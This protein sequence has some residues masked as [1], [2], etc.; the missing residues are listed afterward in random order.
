MGFDP[1]REEANGMVRS[2][3]LGT[4]AMV[5]IVVGFTVGDARGWRSG[6][7]WSVV[8]YTVLLV[9]VI[10]L[11]RLQRHRK[12]SVNRAHWPLGCGGTRP[13]R[14]VVDRSMRPGPETSNEAR[15]L[16]PRACRIDL[17]ETETG[18]ASLP[19]LQARAGNGWTTAALAQPR[20]RA[21]HLRV[22]GRSYLSRWSLAGPTLDRAVP[23]LGFLFLLSI[24]ATLLDLLRRR[25]D[26][27]DR[28]QT[29]CSLRMVRGTCPGLTSR[30]RSGA[31][32]I[33]RSEI[34]FQRMIGGVRFLPG[35]RVNL[36][37]VQIEPRLDP[38]SWA[39]AM[40]VMP[41]SEVVQL[42]TADAVVCGGLSS[43]RHAVGYRT[44]ASVATRGRFGMPRRD[45]SP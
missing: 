14:S 36:D 8:T 7:L 28:H 33:E 12:P 26:A 41:G 35:R 45:P 43:P 31:A 20:R 39:D 17:G 5:A 19:C 24:G 11:F 15:E 18:L 6:V 3:V 23:T 25:N 34:R 21:R 30:W 42:T 4:P 40:S 10:A 16:L 2:L 37:L 38:T 29:D 13:R 27:R 22:H 32:V 44:V 1:Y 9:V